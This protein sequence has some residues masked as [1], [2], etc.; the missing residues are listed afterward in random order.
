VSKV[1]AFCD[2]AAAGLQHQINNQPHKKPQTMSN[3]FLVDAEPKMRN[4]EK[5]TTINQIRGGGKL[6]KLLLVLCLLIFGEIIII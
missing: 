2:D 6:Q 5:Q 4:E 1:V 3:E